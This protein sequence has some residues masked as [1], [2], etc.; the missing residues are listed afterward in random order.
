MNPQA[1]LHL[2]GNWKSTPACAE[3]YPLP[4]PAMTFA[5]ALIRH[6]EFSAFD[7]FQLTSRRRTFCSAVH[8]EESRCAN[9]SI[10]NSPGIGLAERRIIITGVVLYDTGTEFEF[11]LFRS[12]LS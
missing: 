6:L 9:S 3:P 5:H 8:T 2:E 12:I 4:S 1:S 7:E 11:A 10:F